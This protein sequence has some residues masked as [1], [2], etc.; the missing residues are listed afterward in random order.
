MASRSRGIEPRL[1][2]ACSDDTVLAL[3]EETDVDFSSDDDTQDPCIMNPRKSLHKSV[4]DLAVA[5][6]YLQFKQR[7]RKKGVKN[8]I[9]IREF[10]IQLGEKLIADNLDSTDT[11]DPADEFEELL[12]KHKKR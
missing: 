1:G 10:K 4:E 6:S 7:E 8:V 5:N 9:G 3:L 12:P 2:I 11:D